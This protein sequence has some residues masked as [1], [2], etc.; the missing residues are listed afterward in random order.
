[1]TR[2]TI[3]ALA[4]ALAACS[5]TIPA[6]TEAEVPRDVEC[7]QHVDNTELVKDPVEFCRIIREEAPEEL[8]MCFIV[9]FVP[10][11]TALIEGIKDGHVAGIASGEQ[12]IGLLVEWCMN[13]EK[14]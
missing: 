1:M 14:A 4:L 5:P 12:I 3:V 2:I 13:R 8:Q 11:T 6:M 10:Y 9:N 7:L